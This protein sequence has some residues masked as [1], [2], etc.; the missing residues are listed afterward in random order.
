MSARRE[1][2]DKIVARALGLAALLSFG[3]TFAIVLLLLGE[4]A[5]IFAKVSLKELLLSVRFGPMLDP[6]AYG[7]WPLLAGTALVATLGL[8]I[9]LPIAL[10]IAVYLSEYCPP[11]IRRVLKAALDVLA[12]VPAV[13]YGFVALVYV[14]PFLQPHVAEIGV[15]SALAGAIVL[16]AMLVPYIASLADDAIYAVPLELREAGFALGAS[17]L[18]VVRRAVLPHAVS[19]VV[20]ACFL[21]VARAMGETMIVLIVCGL[22]P[23]L[24][25]DPRAPVQT[26][27]A[28]IAQASLSDTGGTETGSRL[29]FFVA[30]M[31][32]ALT[33]ALNAI[34]ARWRERFLRRMP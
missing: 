13:V 18:S 29:M 1:T 27:A 16:A 34:S 21:G 17:R 4:S 14:S 12:G 7:V 9:A 15:Y 31:L 33:F 11:R 26:L 24:T 2:R 25:L 10:I 32:F 3:T 28:F 23:T 20:A 19:G 5:A 8:A 30:T 6:P 22:E